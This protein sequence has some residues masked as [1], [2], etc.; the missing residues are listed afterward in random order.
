MTSRFNQ[1]LTKL[2][3]S[4][5]IFVFTVFLTPN[6]NI[7]NIY[8]LLISS[9]FIVIIDYL[10]ATITGIHDYPMGRGVVGFFSAIV[11]IYATQFFIPGYQIS[12]ISSIIAASIYS[13]IDY[14]LPN[15][16]KIE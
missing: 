11:I 9:L 14:I 2:L 6:F 4:I 15:N 1:N 16:K 8:I 13:F 3:V 10:V 12:I 5:S 7:D